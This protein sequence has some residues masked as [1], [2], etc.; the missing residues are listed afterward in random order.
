MRSILSK[1]FNHITQHANYRRRWKTLLF[2]LLL[3]CSATSPWPL[4]LEATILLSGTMTV[5]FYIVI[6]EACAVFVLASQAI[7]LCR[8]YSWFIQM[9]EFL[10]KFWLMS[11]SYAWNHI[12]P[13]HPFVGR[14]GLSTYILS[15]VNS[16]AM[17]VTMEILLS[18][19][20][21]RTMVCT[22]C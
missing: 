18:D 11:P 14:C 3:L 22:L 12:A 17:N 4:L 6:P 5:Y 15:I 9:A 13:T 10:L 7:S 19:P 8:M 21:C 16:A 1:S 20:C 2:K